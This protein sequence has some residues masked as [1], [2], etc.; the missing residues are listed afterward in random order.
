[1]DSGWFVYVLDV[2]GSALHITMIEVLMHGLRD[3]VITPQG[4]FL[5]RGYTT[6]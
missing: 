4:F 5:F 2:D 1:M 3:I 6:S